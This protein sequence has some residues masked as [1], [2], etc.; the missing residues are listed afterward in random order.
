VSAADCLINN[1]EKVGLNVDNLDQG[2]SNRRG[3]ADLPFW[4]G[5]ENI[6]S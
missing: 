2:A 1:D 5:G 4:R 6:L 3:A